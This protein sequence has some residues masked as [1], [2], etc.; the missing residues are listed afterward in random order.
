M[1]L[2]DGEA[3]LSSVLT[4]VVRSFLMELGYGSTQAQALTLKLEEL[5]QFDSTN[6]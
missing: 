3:S 5:L 1:S 4:P 2:A 6:A